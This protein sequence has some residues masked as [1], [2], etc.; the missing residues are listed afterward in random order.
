MQLRHRYLSA[1]GECQHS[2]PQL[3]VQRKCPPYGPAAGSLPAFLYLPALPESLEEKQILCSTE[4]YRQ[5]HEEWE[6]S[7]T[8]LVNIG[9][10]PSSPDFCLP[11]ALRRPSPGAPLPPVL[12]L[13]FN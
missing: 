12:G 3:P 13:L 4:I 7:D 1:G 9:D 10:Y 6:R 2:C 11:V 5:I 8:A